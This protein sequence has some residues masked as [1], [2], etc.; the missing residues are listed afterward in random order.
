MTCS[1]KPD[2]VYQTRVNRTFTISILNVSSAHTGQYACQVANYDPKLIQTCHLQIKFDAQEDHGNTFAVVL[3][4]VLVG[5]VLLAILVIVVVLKCRRRCRCKREDRPESREGQPMIVTDKRVTEEFQEFLLKKVRQMFPDML[6][7]CYF[8]PPIYFNKT[9]YKTETVAGQV[10]YIPDLPD[11]SDVL[12]N[13]AMETVLSCLRRILKTKQERMFVLTHFNYDDYLNNPD[14]N[15]ITH[16]LPVPA[17]LKKR[18]GEN[19]IGCFDFLILHRQYGVVVGVVKTVSDKYDGSE[20]T[21]KKTDHLLI[22]EVSEAIL[23]L[24]K[25]ARMIKHLM[26]DQ[27]HP[28]KV[29]QAI[30][31]PNAEHTTL[32]RVLHNHRG[33]AQK[34]RKCFQT[35]DVPVQLCLCADQLTDPHLMTW[36]DS[37]MNKST[38]DDIM[39][40]DLY[41]CLIARFCGPATTSAVDIPRTPDSL[42]LPK[43][44][45]QAVSVTGDLFDRCTLYPGMT[46]LIQEPRVFLSGPPGTGKTR[47]LGL[48]GRKWLFEGHVVQ[49]VNTSTELTSATIQLVKILQEAQSSDISPNGMVVSLN[50]NIERR[51]DIRDTITKL[52]ATAGEKPVCVLVDD[53]EINAEKSQQIHK[54]F[55]SLRMCLPNIHCWASSCS[56]DNAPEGWRSEVLTIPISCP[57]DVL[58]EAMKEKRIPGVLPYSESRFTSPTKGMPVISISHHYCASNSHI[59]YKMCGNEILRFLSQALRISGIGANP[60]TMD[61]S[62]ALR[63]RDILMLFEDDVTQFMPVVTAFK[64]S[65]IPVQIIDYKNQEDVLNS[66]VVIAANAGFLCGIKRKVVIYV[67]GDTEPSDISASWNK[68]RSITSCTS[69]LVFVSFAF[70]N[71]WNA[72]VKVADYVITNLIGPI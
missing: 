54:F 28:L 44:L 64:E 34:L 43:T 30:V 70:K 45:D 59:D 47:L 24:T 60:G 6:N 37:L 10:V 14:H 29:R 63:Y 49:I 22:T 62:T 27:N 18:K 2:I 33:L 21:K 57:P 5:A 19:K 50:C 42:P 16:G 40:D 15:F 65:G 11:P 12:Y 51:Q 7:T 17:G 1:A 9:R 61:M 36:W 72:V 48:V 38:D 39:K 41:E 71:V 52:E 3:S 4:V 67:E 20:D 58:R 25:A 69:Q 56:T 53:L 68:L 26:S 13:K 32:N 8:V 55:K 23:Q 46:D 66:N 31:L 35:E